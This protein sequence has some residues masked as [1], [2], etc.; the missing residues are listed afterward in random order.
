MTHIFLSSS[1]KFWSVNGQK[2]GSRLVTCG[3]PQGS[4][5]GPL[6]FIIYLNDFEKCL[7]FFTASTYADDMHVTLTF[8]KID[9]L[10]T[11]AHRELT[12]IS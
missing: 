7:E 9:D 12:N 2:S 8:N 6:L 10:I 5:L 1:K 4:C 3:I 11:T